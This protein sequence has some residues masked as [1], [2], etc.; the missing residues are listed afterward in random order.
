MKDY[1]LSKREVEVV[2]RISTGTTNKEAAD[3]LF[4]SEKTIKFH[5][6]NIYKKM[7]CKSRSQLIVAC[8]DYREQKTDKGASSDVDGSGTNTPS[9]CESES[10]N[11]TNDIQMRT[12]G[13]PPGYIQ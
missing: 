3:Q 12:Q 7:K 11:T 6:T 9:A 4:V 8:F 2:E 13:L 5:L 1:R 10:G